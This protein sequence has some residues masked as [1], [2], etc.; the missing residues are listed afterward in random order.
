MEIYVNVISLSR[1]IH[2]FSR[3]SSFNLTYLVLFL[4]NHNIFWRS[5]PPYNV[6]TKLSNLYFSNSVWKNFFCSVLYAKLTLFCRNI[7]TCTEGWLTL[8]IEFHMKMQIY[9]NFILLTRDI[10][11]FFRIFGNFLV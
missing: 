3:I 4:C 10:Y 8:I 9:V 7:I 11:I 5:L 1:G 2:I 6:S